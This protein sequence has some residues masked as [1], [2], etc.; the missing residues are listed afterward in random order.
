MFLDALDMKPTFPPAAIKAIG[1]LYGFD[2]SENAEIRNRFYR[3]A[4]RSGPEYAQDAASEL[5]RSAILPAS[6]VALTCELEWVVNKGRM[7]FCRPTY[8]GIFT[9]DP[10]LAKKTF[11]KHVEFYVSLPRRM[12]LLYCFKW[13]VLA[14]C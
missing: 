14:R 2:S 8:R 13:E 4:L 12:P 3:I 7:K 6:W 11:L 9:Q 5:Q 10:E 1:K